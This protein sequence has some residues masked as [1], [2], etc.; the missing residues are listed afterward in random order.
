MIWTKEN[1]DLLKSYLGD[2]EPYSKIAKKFGC[3]HDAIQHAVRRYD[4][5]Q[6]RAENPKAEKVVKSLEMEELND[7]SFDELKEKAKLKWIPAK[8]NIKP[9]K[10]SKFETILVFGDIHIPHQDDAS[11]KAVL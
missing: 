7:A 8:S 4:L 11:I 9:N 3:S 2:G 6:F 1:I 10:K 5:S